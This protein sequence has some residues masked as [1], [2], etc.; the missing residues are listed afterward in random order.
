MWQRRTHFEKLGESGVRELLL[1]DLPLRDGIRGSIVA[2]RVSP[3]EE[4]VKDEVRDGRDGGVLV[5]LTLA[6]TREEDA[7]DGEDLPVVAEDLLDEA[8]KSFGTN[9]GRLSFSHG[10]DEELDRRM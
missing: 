5:S 4:G 9:D 1:V 7:M 3:L 6:E 8:F 10:G 2:I